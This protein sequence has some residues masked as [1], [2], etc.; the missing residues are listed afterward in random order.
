MIVPETIR[1]TREVIDAQG[2]EAL[3]V[4][5]LVVGDLPLLGWSGNASH[6]G[7]VAGRLERV[8]RGEIEY[9]AV[10]APGGEPV[11]K[12]CIDYAEQPG[13]ATLMQ[14]ETHSDL[15][16]L[17]IATRLIAEAEHRVAR[18][19]VRRIVIGVEDSN[20]RARSLY[21]RLGYVMC[22]RM[23]AAWDRE[24]E[25]GVVSLYKTELVQLEKFL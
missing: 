7:N 24:D 12:L 1:A 9:L 6:I 16:R 10:R 2:V 17:G 3:E 23:A 5:D 25:H 21:E 20:P 4:G 19:G 15:R 14:L 22:G 8:V 13:V 18:R 11:A